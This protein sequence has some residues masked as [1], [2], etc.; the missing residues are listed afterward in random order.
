MEFM[1]VV[2]KRYACK[3]Y[4]GAP[5]DPAQLDAVLE[6]GRLAPTAK[7][8]Q[9]HHVYVAESPEALAKVDQVTPCRYGAPAVLIVTGNAAKSFV[10]PGGQLNAG[11]EDAA[12]VA[13]HMMLAATD[14]GLESVWVNNFNPA[15][16]S[17]VFGLPEDET[18]LMLLDLGHA[19]AE[20]GAPLEKHTIRKPLDQL[21][22]RL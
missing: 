15:E 3:K 9:E 10:Y 11:L 22:T 1:E 12:I 14:A 8:E 6:A 4:D 19:A 2:K 5:I 20:G 21:V 7:D 13:T 17:K 16:V 18:V